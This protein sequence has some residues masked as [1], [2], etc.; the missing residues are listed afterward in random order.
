ML[1]TRPHDESNGDE[2]DPSDDRSP[3]ETHD[4]SDHQRGS[5]DPAGSSSFSHV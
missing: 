3:D 4:A 2:D 5:D 1:T